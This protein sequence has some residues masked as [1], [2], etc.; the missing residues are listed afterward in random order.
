[1]KTRVSPI[2]LIYPVNDYSPG[3][4]HGHKYKKY[5]KCLSMMIPIYIKQHLSS[6]SG[7][8]LAT[9]RLSCEK[10]LLIKKRVFMK[11]V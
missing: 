5:K 1:M 3:H 4:G 9:L 2:S 7:E 8:S 10:V 6:N 11:S